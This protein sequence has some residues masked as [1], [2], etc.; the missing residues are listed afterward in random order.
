M[1]FSIY[2]FIHASKRPEIQKKRF[3]WHE[4]DVL[5]DE[6]EITRRSESI[7]E[8]NPRITSGSRFFETDAHY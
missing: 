4:S 5:S 1:I 7:V 6:E 3:N 2:T 8:D